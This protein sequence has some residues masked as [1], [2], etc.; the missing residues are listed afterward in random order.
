MTLFLSPARRCLT[1]NDPVYHPFGGKLSR[2]AL[3]DYS[4]PQRDIKVRLVLL[5]TKQVLLVLI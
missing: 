3:K 2:D 5:Y 4:G 1:E